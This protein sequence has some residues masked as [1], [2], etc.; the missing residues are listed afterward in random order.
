MARIGALRELVGVETDSFSRYVTD[1]MRVIGFQRRSG[2][3]RSVHALAR[4]FGRA[5]L[6]DP[7]DLRRPG[8]E[9]F[10]AVELPRR[11]R[12]Q[13]DDESRKI[14]QDPSTLSGAFTVVNPEA[15]RTQGANDIVRDRIKV[16]RRLAAGDHE[17]VSK[18]TDA[19]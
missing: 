2:Q 10:Q 5:A 12:K 3:H 7:H 19:A 13:V 16:A 4:S 9:L 1:L 17:K 6:L 8:P 11:T 18:L 14:E 15:V